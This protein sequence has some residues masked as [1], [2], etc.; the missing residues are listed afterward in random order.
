MQHSS[1]HVKP[2][3]TEV[4]W[5]AWLHAICYPV[6]NVMVICRAQTGGKIDCFVAGVGTGG[7]IS[8]AGKFL[9]ERNPDIRV[10]PP[11]C[12]LQRDSPWVDC[13]AIPVSKL[14]HCPYALT[15]VQEAMTYTNS[16]L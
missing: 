13:L 14:L 7:T 5:P 10:R 15:S 1:G 2:A 6:S 3:H 8:G 16:C 11:G 4:L 9:K 12:E